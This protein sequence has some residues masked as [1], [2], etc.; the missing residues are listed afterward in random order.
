MAA[1]KVL[2]CNEVRILQ[3]RHKTQSSQEEDRH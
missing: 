3:R 2:F 1:H